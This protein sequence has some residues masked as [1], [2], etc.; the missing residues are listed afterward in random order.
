MEETAPVKQ[1]PKCHNVIDHTDPEWHGYSL[2]DLVYCR[3]VNM[4]KQQLITERLR[5]AVKHIKLV[6][7]QQA[8]QGIFG[9]LSSW[10]S[11]ADYGVTGFRLFKRL[12]RLYRNM[13]SR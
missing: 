5:Q 12:R 3:Q 2:D 4:V 6:R 9:T 1:P 8:S 10:L 7:E 13:R 11:Y